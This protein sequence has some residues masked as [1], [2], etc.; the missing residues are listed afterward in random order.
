MNDQKN[1][2]GKMIY[3]ND[4]NPDVYEGYWV[5]GMRHGEGQYRFFNG[6]LYKGFWI[7]DKK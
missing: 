6:D 7:N 1:G 2:W 5:N 4:K 3:N